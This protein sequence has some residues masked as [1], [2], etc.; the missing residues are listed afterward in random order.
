MRGFYKGLAFPFA[1]QV[2]FKVVIFTTNGIARRALE[3]RGLADSPFG[4]YACG[5]LSGKHSNQKRSRFGTKCS[6]SSRDAV[7]NKS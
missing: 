2:M 7:T 1:A 3:K 4:I 6:E 5:A